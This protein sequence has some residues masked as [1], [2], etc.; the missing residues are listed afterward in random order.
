M[1]VVDEVIKKA[2]ISIGINANF[3]RELINEEEREL[4]TTLTRELGEEIDLENLFSSIVKEFNTVYEHLKT[5]W[6]ASLLREI[7]E[8]MELVG[9]PVIVNLEYENLMGILED[10]DDIGR[11]ILKVDRERVFISPGDANGVYP[12]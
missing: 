11:I 10:I 6:K 3:D 2:F 9:M 8:H 4:S 5:G 12:V 7:R 1:T